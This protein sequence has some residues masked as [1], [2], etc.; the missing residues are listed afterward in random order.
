MTLILKI[1]DFI[2]CFLAAAVFST[3]AIF[4]VAAGV[5]ATVYVL[6]SF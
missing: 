4:A 5:R 2:F 1:A 3:A 6:N